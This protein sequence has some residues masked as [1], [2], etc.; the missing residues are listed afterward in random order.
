M[1]ADTFPINKNVSKY[2][3]GT[4]AFIYFSY[5]LFCIWIGG[6]MMEIHQIPGGVHF[7]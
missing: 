4:I 3:A 1:K 5:I 6:N 2:Y 7:L